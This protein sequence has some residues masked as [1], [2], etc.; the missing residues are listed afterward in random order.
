MRW[1]IGLSFVLLFPSRALALELPELAARTNP[2][3]VLLTLA[4]ASGA[5][6][7]NG[8]GFFVSA[9]GR[10]ITNFHVIQGASSVSATLSDGHEI[11]ILGVL[12][13]DPAR[14]IAVLKAEGPPF[15]ALPLG[16]SQVIRPGDEVVVIGSP[17][18][19]SGTVSAGIV[20][21][22]R[23]K[24]VFQDD[25]ALPRRILDN[26]NVPA[27]QSWGI[28]ITAAISAGSSGSPIMTRSGD[29][30]AVAVGTRLDGQSLN[31]GVPIQVAKELLSGIDAGA[32]PKPLAAFARATSKDRAQGPEVLTNLGISAAVFAGVAL[33]YFLVSRILSAFGRRRSR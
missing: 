13:A 30:I 20:S 23:E 4:D 9:D 2:S 12:A 29:V 15:P 8:T 28:Q 10:M 31:F 32:T 25:P 5:K 33:V 18:G 24:G 14:D 26:K 1:W 7:G 17:L 21:A 19:L 16:D 11:K 27:T 6:L 22:V 3:V